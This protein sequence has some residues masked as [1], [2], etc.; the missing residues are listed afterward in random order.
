MKYSYAAVILAVLLKVGNPGWVLFGIISL[1]L[2]IVIPVLCFHVISHRRYLTASPSAQRGPSLSILVSNGAL[3][4]SALIC[5]D[6]DDKRG[7]I[8]LTF[9]GVSDPLHG[10]F[11]LV[12]T[13]L[14]AIVPIIDLSI[15]FSC[16]KRPPTDPLLAAIS[17][18]RKR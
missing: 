7:Y 13:L 5:P 2:P 8:F 18:I 9:F 3:V 16:K 15:Y 1:G 10:H 4:F 12:A 11:L 6:F 14:F 17:R